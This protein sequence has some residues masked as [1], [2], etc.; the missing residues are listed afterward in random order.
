PITVAAVILTVSRVSNGLERFHVFPI[1]AAPAIPTTA[2]P[3]TLKASARLSSIDRW[4][5]WA[6][7]TT[8]ATSATTAPLPGLYP[9]PSRSSPLTR[10]RPREPAHRPGRVLPSPPRF[11]IPATARKDGPFGSE[12]LIK[13]GRI[14]DVKQC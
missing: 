12:V 5:Q 4:P 2:I 6:K 11:L 13:P 8:S 7:T 14:T 9:I 1:T 10:P 3:T